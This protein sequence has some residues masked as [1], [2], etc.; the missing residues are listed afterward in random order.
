MSL[1]TRLRLALEALP[2]Q[3]NTTTLQ[4]PA[5]TSR[6]DEFVAVH[7][8]KTNDVHYNGVFF[9]W[10]RHFLWLYNP[11]LRNLCR[12]TGPVPY[13]DWTLNSDDP[14]NSTVFDGSACSLRGNGEYYP[15]GVTDLSLINKHLIVALGTG[16]GCVTEGP[17]AK[18]TWTGHIGNDFNITDVPELDDFP[19]S[20]AWDALNKLHTAGGLTIGS[21][22]NDVY[23]SAGDPAIWLHHGMVD[24]AWAIWQGQDMEARR[25]QVGATR[26]PFNDPPSARVAVDEFLD[27]TGLAER[28][29]LKDVTS[30]LDGPYWYVYE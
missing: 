27:F 13:W 15:H 4:A 29:T 9:V 26:T 24:R 28:V 14:R 3:A 12:Y 17:F 18:G 7:L 6:Y 30:T 11:D 2:P 1:W 23:A 20:T 5:V 8:L 19:T 25:Y 22:N 10:H 16:R 21:L